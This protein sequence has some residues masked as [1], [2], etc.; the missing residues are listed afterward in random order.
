MAPRFLVPRQ[1]I[2]PMLSAV[3]AQSPNHWTAREFPILEILCNKIKVIKIWQYICCC[4]VVQSYPTFCDPIDYSMPGFPVLH[5]L[6]ILWAQTHVHWIGDA[7]QPSHPLS[8]P[9]PLAINKYVLRSSLTYITYIE[10]MY[11]KVFTMQWWYDFKMSLAKYSFLLRYNSH[12]E[13]L[14]LKHTIQ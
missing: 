14:S 7:I 6:T 13:N 4:S 12:M 9:S 3:E 8:S 10:Y 5:C 2:K 11:C 1:R